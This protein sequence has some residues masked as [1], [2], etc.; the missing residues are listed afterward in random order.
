M[1]NVVVAAQ[2]RVEAGFKVL[3]G[4][5]GEKS[6]PAEVD[7]NGGDV[8]LRQ[9]ARR[10]QHGAVA[11]HHD[12]EVNQLAE[13]LRP[14]VNALAVNVGRGG[15]AQQ[16]F[17][18]VLLEQCPNLGNGIANVAVVEFAEQPDFVYVHK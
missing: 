14:V 9:I 6:E 16:D 11:A 8:V 5:V 18:V 17:Q 10:A 13:G 4:D 1:F 2:N 15:A 3:H 12:G 7:A